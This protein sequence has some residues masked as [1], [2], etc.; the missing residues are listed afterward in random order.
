MKTVQDSLFVLHELGEQ[1][2]QQVD[3]STGA[4]IESN[5]LAVSQNWSALEQALSRQKS[6]LQVRRPCLA[7]LSLSLPVASPVAL[8]KIRPFFQMS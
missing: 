8:V 1:L 4:A 2:K 7:I 6:V 3:S 5:H